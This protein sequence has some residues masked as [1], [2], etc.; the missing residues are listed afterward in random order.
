MTT[1]DTGGGK[2]KSKGGKGGP[3]IEPFDVDDLQMSRRGPSGKPTNSTYPKLN[4]RK[5]TS[6]IKKV[7]LETEL[8]M[9]RPCGT[10]N[11]QSG[12]VCMYR[13]GGNHD[14]CKIGDRECYKGD[15]M[16][17]GEDRK[18]K[19]K[20]LNEVKAC[21]GIGCKT[22]CDNTDGWSGCG[23]CSGHGPYTDKI[24]ADGPGKTKGVKGGS[25]AKPSSRGEKAKGKKL[26]ERNLSN[27]IRKVMY[28]SELLT[29]EEACNFKGKGTRKQNEDCGKCVAK[30]MKPSGDFT[31]I[32]KNCF[33]D[34]KQVGGKQ[35]GGKDCDY[36]NGETMGAR[37]CV[38]TNPNKGCGEKGGGRKTKSRR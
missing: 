11:C 32:D 3:Y 14:C 23:D 37:G 20:R 1:N 31:A 17:T 33:G 25:K 4:E 16:K 10:G 18:D 29:E 38:C 2:T 6:I 36:E 7:M 30:H 15:G 12:Y 34:G 5:L 21:P 8:L 27:I 35:V 24:V 9:E 13:G 26:N 19:G 28:E 22:C